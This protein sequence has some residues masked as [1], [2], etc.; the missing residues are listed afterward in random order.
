MV[1]VIERFWNDESAATAIEY[2]LLAAIMSVVIVGSSNSIK[3][4]M[5][6]ALTATSSAI[7]NVNS[8]GGG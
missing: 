2:G 3:Q 4:A 6:D 7:A 8:G 1:R 5:Q